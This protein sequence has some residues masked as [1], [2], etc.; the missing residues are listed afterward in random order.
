MEENSFISVNV[1]SRVN[2][3]TAGGGETAASDRSSGAFKPQ[4]AQ[5]GDQKRRNVDATPMAVEHKKT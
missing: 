4:A 1:K 3:T 2:P 5:A